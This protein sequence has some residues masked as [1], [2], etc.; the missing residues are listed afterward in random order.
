[1][2]PG[3]GHAGQEEVLGVVLGH[4]VDFRVGWLGVIAAQDHEGFAVRSE[5]D[6]MRT[7][8]S[9]PLE[10]AQLGDLVELVVT[11]GVGEIIESAPV[12]AYPTAIY[13]DVKAV[14]GPKEAMTA[15]DRGR[16]LLDLQLIAGGN[17][18]DSGPALVA[19]VEAALVV[20]G[21]GD[22]GTLVS[23]GNGVDLFH[24]ETIGVDG[25]LALGGGFLLFGDLLGDTGEDDVLDLHLHRGPGVKLQ[26]QHARE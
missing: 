2:A 15:A 12:S 20:D 26:G 21:H 11:I 14:E 3:I 19:A 17:T 10:S 22:P 9:A 6:R 16:D 8:F 13:A 1:M 4:G 18:P 7:V 23:L 24:L 5:D 25:R